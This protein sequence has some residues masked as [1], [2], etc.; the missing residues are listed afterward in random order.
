VSRE[1]FRVLI[2]T[3]KTH[4]NNGAVGMLYEEI[5]YFKITPSMEMFSLMILMATRPLKKELVEELVTSALAEAHKGDGTRFQRFPSILSSFPR[6]LQP[7]FFSFVLRRQVQ[8]G[9]FLFRHCDQSA[10]RCWQPA[11]RHRLAA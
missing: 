11:A 1:D 10:G 5:K 9:R 2:R 3:A 6:L 7:F 4:R 8:A